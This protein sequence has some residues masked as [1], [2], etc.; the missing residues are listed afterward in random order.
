L[1]HKKIGILGGMS[2]KSTIKYYDL[3]MQKY[4]EKLGNFHYPEIIINSLDFQKVID[5]ELDDVQDDYIEYLLEGL[6]NLSKAG[7]D[8]AVM[9]ANSPHAVYNELNKKT[10]IPILNIV[11]AT[12][13]EAKIRE[14]DDLLLLGIKFTMQSDF[15]LR[16]MAE[17]DIKVVTPTEDDQNEIDYII[18][19]E[20][21]VGDFNRDSKIK[22]LKIIDKYN[23]NGV[24]LGCTE[25]PLLLKQEDS[26]IPLLNTLEIHV[27]AAL[28]YALYSF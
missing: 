27:Q 7:A 18:F 14:L 3:I 1:R 12:A 10:P 16:I 2:H 26:K 15:Y 6:I 28:N 17:N 24:I 9:A 5:L 23:V 21:V 19:N 4:F 22:I 20:L 13:K 11:E 8:F 25:L